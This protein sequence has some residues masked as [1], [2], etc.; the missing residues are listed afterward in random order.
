[1]RY[2]G[3]E[4]GYIFDTQNTY[5]FMIKDYMGRKYIDFNSRGMFK[6]KVE[7]DIIE[8]VFDEFV[9]IKVNDKFDEYIHADYYID[10]KNFYIC[11]TDEEITFDEVLRYNYIVYGAMWTDKGLIY[12][13][14]M[15]KKGEFE[16]L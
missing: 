15:N 2:I 6:I 12:V 16:L 13:A 1:M 4:E 10:Y 7:A 9:I 5:P 11:N 14:K 8:N 3:T